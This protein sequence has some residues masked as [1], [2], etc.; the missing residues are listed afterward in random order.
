[1]KNWSFLF[2]L[3]YSLVSSGQTADVLIK[4]GRVLDGTGNSWF[5]ADVAV[6]DGKIWKIGKLQNLTAKKVIDAKSLIVAPGFIDVHTHIEGDEDK[7]PTADNF[8]YDGVTT[9]V[10]GNCG[11]SNTDLKEYW[12]H[13]DSLKLSVNVASLI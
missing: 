6:K 2:F 1:M 3:F 8:I 13:L 5:H 12:Q 9:V 4:N 7:N 11:A 10:T